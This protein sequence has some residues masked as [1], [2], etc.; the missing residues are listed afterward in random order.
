[1]TVY[2]DDMEAPF[3]RMI[4]CHMWADTYPEL[5]AMAQ[6]IGVDTKWLQYP[7]KASWVH[8]DIAKSMRSKAVVRGAYPVAWRDVSKAAK[9]QKLEPSYDPF[10]PGYRE[11]YMMGAEGAG[12]KD[13]PYKVGDDKWYGWHD[14]AAYAWT[15][16]G[17]R[18]P[19][20]LYD[21]D[22]PF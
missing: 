14:G 7:P 19:D 21:D 17:L 12:I 6:A 2:V 5:I 4:M 10:Y 3:G 1:M 9:R 13:N 15:E 22:I 16:L 8:F 20:I 11:G 18:V